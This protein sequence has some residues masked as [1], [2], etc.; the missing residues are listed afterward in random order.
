MLMHVSGEHELLF[1]VTAL[2]LR[3]V[4]QEQLVSATAEVADGRQLSLRDRLCELKLLT[5]TEADAVA[6]VVREQM[7]RC[8]N[9]A[10]QTLDSVGAAEAEALSRQSAGGTSYKAGA[11]TEAAANDRYVTTAPR[12]WS[13]SSQ[14]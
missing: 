1:G 11:P 10:R 14:Q 7:A 2:Q 4:T 6:A 5:P 8:G 9:D 3:F 13:F 12:A